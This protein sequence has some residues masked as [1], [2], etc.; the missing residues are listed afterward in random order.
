MLDTNNLGQNV[1]I[2]FQVIKNSDKVKLSKELDV[3]LRAGK[4]IYIWSKTT[5]PLEMKVYCSSVKIP[6]SKEEIEI[7][8]KA[9]ELRKKNKLFKDIADELKIE[10]GMVGYYINTPIV[11]S[12]SLDDWILDYYH[13]DSTVYEKAD[14]VVEPDPN[15]ARRFTIGGYITN[16]IEKIV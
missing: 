12:V 9:K 8:K 16:F 2:D 5:T 15:T 6:I 11:E 4:K 7:H 1:F 14:I 3:L 13:K 10:I